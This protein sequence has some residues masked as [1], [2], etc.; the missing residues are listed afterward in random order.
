[1]VF[2][3]GG[4]LEGNAYQL[5]SMLPVIEPLVENGAQ[6]HRRCVGVF[7]PEE[8]QIQIVGGRHAHA[9]SRTVIC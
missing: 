5:K 8:S 7:G 9:P 6:Q 3:D 2:G 1:M 4:A